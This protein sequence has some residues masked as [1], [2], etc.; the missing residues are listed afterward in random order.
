MSTLQH[1][2][3]ARIGCA[4]LL[5]MRRAVA[6]SLLLVAA[7][8]GC[9]SEARNAAPSAQRIAAAF[10]GSPPALARLHGQAG[11]LLPASPASFKALLASLRGHPVVVNKWGSWCA[12]CRAEFPTFQQVSVTR[13]RSVAFLG[14]DG[15]DNRGEAQAFLKR[16]PVSYPSYSDPDAHIAFAVNASSY[17]PTTLFFDTAGRLAYLHAGPYVTPAA[18]LSDIRRYLHA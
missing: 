3:T 16:F 12:P 7:G 5:P 2:D 13:G 14:L 4:N 17:Y 11:Q 6:A 9:G 18:L 1:K 15:G 8:T 10:A